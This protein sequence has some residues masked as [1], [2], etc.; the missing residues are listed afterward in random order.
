MVGLVI[1]THGPVGVAL[2]DCG[3][4]FFPNQS[5]FEA[6][7]LDR[8]ADRSGSWSALQ[9]AVTAVDQQQGVMVLVD[10]FGGTPSNLAMALL[11]REDIAVVTGVNL[12]MVL[13]ALQ[14][15]EHLAVHELAEEVLAY[16][17]RNVTSAAE[18]LQPEY[19]EEVPKGVDP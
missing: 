3:E 9:Q 8:E 16:G 15:R 18:W 12:P 1:F 10:M 19:T 2:R 5:A 11:T 7:A 14:K 13:R 6:I 17:R 4:E